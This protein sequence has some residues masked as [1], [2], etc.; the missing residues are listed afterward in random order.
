MLTYEDM[1][2]KLLGW[3]DQPVTVTVVP[4]F[5]GAMQVAGMGGVLRRA[6]PP[7][8]AL[9]AMTGHGSEILFFYVGDDEDWNR[10]WFAITQAQFERALT[11]PSL[12]GGGDMLV[13]MQ[14][15]VNIAISPV[16]DQ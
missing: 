1:L 5:D 7:P 14:R 16:Q 3:I 15:M 6:S 13:V 4:A 11:S 2:A 9:K 12:T 8:E 10:R